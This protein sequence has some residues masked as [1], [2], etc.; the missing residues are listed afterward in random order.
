MMKEP[1]RGDVRF[2]SHC[3]SL[4]DHE[5]IEAGGWREALVSSGDHLKRVLDEYGDLGFECLL[6]EVER[7][8]IEGCTDCFRPGE[9]IYRVYVRR[10]EGAPT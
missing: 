2:P 4:A 10:R 7:S 8:S 1:G 9:R 6:Q 3:R 5:E